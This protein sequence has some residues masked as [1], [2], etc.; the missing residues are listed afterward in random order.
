MWCANLSVLPGIFFHFIS[1]CGPF[2][3]I[4]LLLLSVA[5]PVPGLWESVFLYILFYC[6]LCPP[7]LIICICDLLI[8]FSAL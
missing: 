6:D 1:S 5:P 2:G 4:L 3:A 7:L 8:I